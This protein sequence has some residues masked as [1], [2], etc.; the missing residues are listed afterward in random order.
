MSYFADYHDF[1][2]TNAERFFKATIFQSPR[3]LA[4]MDCL[5]AGQR[6]EAHRH[7]GRDKVYFVISGSGHF[8]IGDEARSCGPG[9]VVWAPADVTHSVVNE[10]PE[11][12]ELFIV[13]APE[14]G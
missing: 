13:M 3:M 9:S 12:L 1:V 6:Q 5:E 2:G 14:P 8:Q 11:R 4:G 10:G 7:A